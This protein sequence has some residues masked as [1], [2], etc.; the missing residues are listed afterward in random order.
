MQQLVDFLGLRHETLF[1]VGLAA[2]AG[3]GDVKRRC[4]KRAGGPQTNQPT[5]N[6]PTSNQQRSPH[7]TP[8]L[9]RSTHSV[10]HNSSARKNTIGM[11]H[12][13]FVSRTV[14]PAS[15]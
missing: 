12:R 9:L 2:E 13:S 10:Q 7:T 6:Q 1:V 11:S 3:H 5:S 4:L 15:E 14:M 8:H